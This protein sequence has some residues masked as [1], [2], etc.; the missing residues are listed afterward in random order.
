MDSGAAASVWPRALCEDYLTQHTEKTGLKYATAG[1]GSKYLVNEGERKLQLKMP[2]GSLRGARMQVTDVRKP[3]M[4]VADMVDAGQDVHF[5][6]SGQ[7]YAVHRESGV[8]TRFSRKK[9]VFEMEAEVPPFGGQ[10]RA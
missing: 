7:N 10:Q 2:D 3:L 4:S 8:V 5:L 9:N 1:K 6:A